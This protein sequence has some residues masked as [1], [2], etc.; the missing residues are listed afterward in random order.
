M[1]ENLPAELSPQKVAAKNRSEP[2]RITGKLRIAVEAMV[3]E[4]L[5]RK[6]AASKSAMTDHGLRSALRKPHVLAFYRRELAALREG[7]RA[8][9]VHRLVEL[10]EQDENRNAAVKAIQVLEMTDPEIMRRAGEST[11]P[12][13]VIRIIEPAAQPLPL[14]PKTIVIEHEPT[15]SG[16][17]NRELDNEDDDTE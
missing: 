17:R 16:T 2:R 3:W 15:P 5:K 9:N 10:R 7:E 1:T 8:R 14:N 6:D 12:G 4:G 13:I 11:S